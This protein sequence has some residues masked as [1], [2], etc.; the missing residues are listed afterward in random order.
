MTTVLIAI[1]IFSLAFLAMAIGWIVSG[2]R[3]RGSCGGLAGYQDEQGNP[4]CDACTNP[5]AECEEF[6]AK[7]CDT[8]SS[9]VKQSS[10]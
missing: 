1:A 6:R 9:E 2:K 3:L 5:A 10:N 7:I 4:I 8:D